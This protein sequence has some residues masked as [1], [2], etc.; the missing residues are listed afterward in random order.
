MIFIEN[1]LEN[2]IIEKLSKGSISSPDLI[3]AIAE[4][5]KVTEQGVYK[6]L[7]FLID[8]EIVTKSKKTLSL[9]TFWIEKLRTFSENISENY[10][11]KDF[12]DFLSLEE[13][14]KLTY[15]FKDT[16]KLDIHWMHIVL[17]MLKRYQDSPFVI[18][19]PHCWFMLDRTETEPAFF[20]WINKNKKMTFYLLGGKTKLDK[21]LKKKIQSENIKVEIDTEDILPKDKYITIIG[22]Y[23]IYS[24]YG[25]KFTNDVNTF[26]DNHSEL[27]AETIK[28][29]KEGIL[30][31]NKSKITIEKNRVKANKFFKQM[32]KN[33]YVPLEIKKEI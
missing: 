18:Y 1:R 21:A 24:V 29:F 2:K 25:E 16:T 11:I 9:N 15:S 23:I 8:N 22:D 20:D 31:N 19:N 7:A 17:M 5:W 33:H 12:N 14:E 30:K 4:E 13:K 6:A 28:D 27:N 32:T 26:F 10:Y 3:L